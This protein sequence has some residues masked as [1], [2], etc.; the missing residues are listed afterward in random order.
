MFRNFGRAPH[1]MQVDYTSYMDLVHPDDVEFVGSVVGRAL[2]D[3][4]PY[5]FDH[6]IQTPEGEIRV[7]HARGRVDLDAA[8]KPLRIHGTAQDVTELRF[9]EQHL[10]EALEREREARRSLEDLNDE[11]ES[12]VYTV[13]HDLNSPLISFLGFLEFLDKD[14]GTVIPEKGHFYMDRMS[15]SAK[16]MQALIRDLL[17]LSRIGRVQTHPEPVE[18]TPLLEDVAGEIRSSGAEFELEVDELPTVNMNRI[19]ARQLF[20]N[21]LNNSVK[22]AGERARVRVSSRMND[23]GL[24]ELSVADNGPGIPAEHRARVFGVFE[25]LQG[26]T[27]AGEGTG[28][29][30]SICKR[31]V[32]TVEGSIWIADS[33]S[34]LDVR[35]TLPV[36][37]EATLTEDA[38]AAAD[39]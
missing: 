15:N 36:F 30:L 24:L 28:I 26:L 7:L 1:S 22:Y 13:S 10:N 12:F 11:M 39:G 5:E 18:L 17:D 16:Y 14:F 20:A 37:D 8:G 4:K 32:E 31:I 29:G 21:L 23:D 34:G 27:S 9:A 19:R 33:D 38:R 35:F 6:R 25:R 3:F 2:E